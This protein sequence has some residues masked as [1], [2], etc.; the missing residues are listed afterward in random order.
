MRMYRVMAKTLQQARY[1]KIWE[2]HGTEFVP[3]LKD[4]HGFGLLGVNA[5]TGVAS[6]LDVA[7][8]AVANSNPV[9]F[10]REVYFPSRLGLMKIDYIRVYVSRTSRK[11]SC[12]RQL[13]FPAP[14]C[15]LRK[16]IAE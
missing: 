4:P 14:K 8:L 1:E 12:L 2:P 5:P 15:P 7:A 16:H 6:A 13:G 9:S 11:M 3:P 10:E